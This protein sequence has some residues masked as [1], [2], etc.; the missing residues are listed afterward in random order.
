MKVFE[1]KLNSDT[2]LE[3]TN[4]LVPH[5]YPSLHL[6]NYEAIKNYCILCPKKKIY[7]FMNYWCSHR[8]IH[9]ML[10]N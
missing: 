3:F 2:L 1:G 5:Y 9:S 4:G 8:V 10:V 7:K 6:D